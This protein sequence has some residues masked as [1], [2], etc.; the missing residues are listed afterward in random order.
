MLRTE[1]CWHAHDDS[2][3]GGQFFGEV[4]FGFRSFEKLEVGDGVA[5]FDHCDGIGS[6]LLIC[7][8]C[9]EALSEERGDVSQTRSRLR[10][11]CCI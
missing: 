4:D 8:E 10:R 5:C 11:F 9:E 2:L 6:K 7:E 3:A 1:S